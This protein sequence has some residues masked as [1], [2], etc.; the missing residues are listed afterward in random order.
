MDYILHGVTKSWPRLSDFH[1]LWRRK[2]QP[3][4]VLLPGKSHGQRSLVGYSPWGHKESNTT[5]RLHF[6]YSLSPVRLF[7]TPWTAVHQAPL[8]MGFPRQGY[9]SGLPSPS[10]GDLPA[11]GIEP[12]CPALHV[13]SL[14]SE[15]PGKTF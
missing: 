12:M 6:L 2:W 7:A 11:P 3:T 4:P 13:D 10:P 8:L 15:Q 14:P 5:Q 1:F 9:W